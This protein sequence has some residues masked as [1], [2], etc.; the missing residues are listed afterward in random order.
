MVL[1]LKPYFSELQV[2]TSRPLFPL[3]VYDNQ[4]IPEVKCPDYL[5][6]SKTG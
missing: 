3:E 6:D 5:W 2:Y 1:Q 4:F